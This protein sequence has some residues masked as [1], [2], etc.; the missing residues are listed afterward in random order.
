[1]GRL[2]ATYVRLPLWAQHA[3]F[4]AYGVY[5]YWLRFG[6]GFGRAL[7]DY[8]GREGF[9]CSEWQEWQQGRLR[10]V[11]GTAA[12]SVPYYRDHWTRDE[13]S[14]ARAGRLSDLPL[15][16]KDPLRA[17]PDAFV[18]EDVRPGRR[19]IFHTSGS[20]G[21]P[22]STFWTVGELRESMALREVRSARWAGVSFELP[23]ATFSGRI[24][25]PDP[26]SEGPFYRFN[27][28]ERQ[29]Y[30][31]P[32]HLR[33]DTA[34]RYL[35]ALHRHRVEWLTGYAVSYYLLA[36]F[37]L[38]QRLRV[39]PL[40]AIVTTSEKVMP[41]MRQ[42]MEDAFGCRVFEEYST[43]ENAVFAHECDHGRMHISPDVAVVE[44]LR[45]DGTPC[46]IG[47]TGEVVV[48][49][50]MRTYQ[51]LV[52]FRLGDLAAWDDVACPCGRR[53]P[54]LKEVVGR[55]E[56]VIV[57]PDGRRLVRFH[58]VFVGQAHVEEGQIVQEAL[59]RIRVKVVPTDGFSQ[60]D[61]EDIVS[62]VHERM[63]SNLQVIVETVKSIP[64]SAAGKFQAV[65]SH[66]DR[67]SVP[68]VERTGTRT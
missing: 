65:V 67:A 32:F 29:V 46:D 58:G 28:A 36:K 26:S 31:S 41:H 23:R 22:I 13:K 47:E 68:G 39:P 12:T 45:P 43:V 50:L 18:R 2:E 5:W 10:T 37:A 64:R 54:V 52:R 51:P 34:A 20:T 21:T 33:P 44:I 42:T 49:A 8:A 62:R 30:F 7:R 3:A 53:M 27:L 48:T 1:V 14:A 55:I 9:G 19:L 66:I 6:P 11:L 35:A 57:G 25:E 15:L 17:R 56:D 61:V 59:D 60:R 40:R 63:G 24:V 4:S 16:E 38:E